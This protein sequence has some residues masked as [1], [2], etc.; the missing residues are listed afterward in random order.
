VCHVRSSWPIS[1]V[2][3]RSSQATSG[4]GE[5]HFHY[6]NGSIRPQLTSTLHIDNS[7]GVCARMNLRHLTEGGTYLHSEAGGQVCAPDNARLSPERGWSAN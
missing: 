7:S 3:C 1:R 2:A 5:I 4:N 6:E